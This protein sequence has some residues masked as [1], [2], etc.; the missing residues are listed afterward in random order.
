MYVIVQDLVYYRNEILEY[1]IGTEK[2]N[3]T[4]NILL[5]LTTIV[6]KYSAIHIVLI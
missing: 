5:R 4:K 1:R 3:E 2:C 6:G